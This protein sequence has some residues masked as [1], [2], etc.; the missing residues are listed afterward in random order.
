MTSE[1]LKES[2]TAGTSTTQLPNDDVIR[3][4]IYTL[5]ETVDIHNMGIKSFIRSLSKE[6]KVSY[7][8]LKANKKEYITEILTEAINAGDTTEKGPDDEGQEE[9][10]DADE[11]GAGNDDDDDDNDDDGDRKVASSQKEGRGLAQ[12]KIISNALAQF[13]QNLHGAGTGTGT[14]TG[15]PT[16]NDSSINTIAIPNTSSST[17]AASTMMMARTEIVKQLWSY[18]HTHNLQNPDNKREVRLDQPLQAVFGCTTF[19]M[20]TMN[21]YISAH[22]DPFT[23]VDLT[24][25]VQLTGTGTGPRT[26]KRASGAG[27]SSR[28]SPGSATKKTRKAGAQPPYML[29]QALQD[30]VGTNILPRPQVVSKL[31]TYIKRH[32]LQDAKDKREIVCDDKLSL[33]FGNKRQLSMFEMN[34]YISRHLI[35]KVDK[36]LYQHDQQQQQLEDVSEMEEIQHHHHDDTRAEEHDQDGPVGHSMEDEDVK[37]AI[38]N[39]YEV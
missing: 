22:V 17:S 25:K 19:T 28:R 16:G 21:K 7:D 10:A 13:F 3:H 20:F 6:M 29:S 36:S 15:T 18:I 2:T 4:T 34:A 27:T 30:V 33:V 38:K 14:G 37:A 23:P 1:H 26:R 39:A 35:E 8:V 9:D 5:L 31:W 32:N 24:P 11:E 12:K